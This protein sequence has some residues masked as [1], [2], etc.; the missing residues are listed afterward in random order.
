MEE[1][2]A[3]L[4]AGALAA[5]PTD[6][7]Y[8]IA[9]LPNDEG[10]AALFAAKGR[11]REKPLPVLAASLEDLSRLV[12]IDERARRVAERFWPGPLTLVLPRAPGFVVDLGGD[13]E[14]VGVRVPDHPVARDLLERVGPL[15]VSS[16]NRAGD[17]PARSAVE[18]R[19]A[20]GDAVAAY[21]D[22]GA[23]ATGVPSTVVSLQGSP[24]VLR[25]GAVDGAEVLAVALAS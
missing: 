10:V 12:Q 25:A 7:V 3:A 8:G 1:A 14:T 21:L 13:G 11:P 17:P 18:A 24:R 20:L 4:Q 19:A 2:V 6:T 23:V 9:A 16:A 5:I 15:V 22:G